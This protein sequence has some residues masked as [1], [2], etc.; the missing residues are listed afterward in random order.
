MLP[1]LLAEPSIERVVVVARRPTGRK[2]PKLDERIFDLDEMEEH[3]SAFAVDA[4]ICAL[5]TTIR[6]AGSQERFRHVDHDLPLVA[7]RLGL[8]NGATHYLLVS[9]IGANAK[10]R[11]FYAR[12]KGEVEAAL[13]ALPYPRVTIVRPSTLL[14]NR[15]E[16]RPGEKIATKLGFLMPASIKPIEASVVARALVELMKRDDAGARI[17]ESRALK[18]L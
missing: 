15:R 5:G 18:A 13:L 9:S 12:V 16:F 2:H 8:A 1:L 11:I 14:G 6:T 10:S 7:A 4:I 17:V 3:A